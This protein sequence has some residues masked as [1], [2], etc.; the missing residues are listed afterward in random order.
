M[1]DDD[2]AINIAPRAVIA[3]LDLAAPRRPQWSIARLAPI[4][5]INP[6]T[7]YIEV[8]TENI[9]SDMGMH[10]GKP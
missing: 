2:T 9:G 3:A 1:T 7:V 4:L 5:P 8:T 6:P 10:T